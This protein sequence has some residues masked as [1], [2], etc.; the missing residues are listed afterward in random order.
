MKLSIFL[1]INCFPVSGRKEG[2]HEGFQVVL[3][4]V[5]GG[6]TALQRGKHENVDTDW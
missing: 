4:E 2:G 6:G 1:C 3:V 5:V